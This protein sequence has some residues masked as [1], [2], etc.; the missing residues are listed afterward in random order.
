L[1]GFLEHQEIF[2]NFGDFK[3]KM[4]F[5]GMYRRFGTK[6]VAYYLPFYLKFL[7]NE[8]FVPLFTI[9]GELVTAR[10]QFCTPGMEH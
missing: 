3:K 2:R 9:L 7:R 1:G 10:L 6:I 4:G 8:N 5:G